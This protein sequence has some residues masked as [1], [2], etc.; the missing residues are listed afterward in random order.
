MEVRWQDNKK[1]RAIEKAELMTVKAQHERDMLEA[2]NFRKTKEL[3]EAR[4]LQ[5]SM[6][7]KTIPKL[8]NLEIAVFMKPATEVGGDY[9]D[10]QLA[11]DNS[12]TIAIGDATGH[13]AKAGTMVTAAKSM[14]TVLTADFDILEIL[15]RIN[16]TFLFP[17]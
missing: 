7:P 11:G 6:L 10:F 17:D 1:K 13:G 9:Y 2:E 16:Q 5:L 14:F 12:L 4:D 15:Q 8:P 3:E